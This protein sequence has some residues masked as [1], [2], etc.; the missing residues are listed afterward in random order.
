MDMSGISMDGIDQTG[1]ITVQVESRLTGNVYEGDFKWR[2]RTLADL[3]KIAASV[4]E[5]T[6]G[7]RIVDDGHSAILNA[8]AELGIVT[9]KSPD[10]WSDVLVNV[11]TGVVMAVYAKYVEWFRAPFREQREARER[12][13]ARLDNSGAEGD[14]E[15]E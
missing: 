9:Q 13:K 12:T 5:L 8:I 11:D 10:W 7:S 6:Q 4:S 14:R 3:G 1:V 2:R 15:E